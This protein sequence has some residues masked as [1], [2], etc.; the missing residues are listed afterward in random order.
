[1]TNHLVPLVSI[2]VPIYGVEDYIEKCAISILNQTYEN[3]EYI[4]VDDCTK[5]N[6]V[7]I[8][9]NV[10]EKYPNRME[11]CIIIKHEMNKGL[12]AARNTGVNRAKGDFVMHVD[13]DD[14]LEENAVELFVLK[15]FEGDYD[16]V[17]CESV[18]EW[19]N[20][21]EVIN[22][23][24]VQNKTEYLANIL[25]GRLPHNMWGNLIRIELYRRNNVTQ[26]EAV[27][28]GEDYA[29]IPIL[30]FYAKNIGLL[31][32]GLYHYNFQNTTSYV[33]NFSK[34][35]SEESWKGIDNIYMF[36]ERHDSS[37]LKYINQYK[38]RHIISYMIAS[39]R[40]KDHEYYNICKLRERNL[41]YVNTDFLDF[42]YKFFYFL[43]FK[44]LRR[45]YVSIMTDVWRIYKFHIKIK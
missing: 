12:A 23:C 16:I 35:K 43:K 5:D 31:H 2:I 21:S 42:G 1:M 8:L 9:R 37:Y 28:M 45:I 15:Q 40:V 39:I 24:N 38:L 19:K 33:H 7:I 10:I 44:L 30:L 13:S 18:R 14:W 17:S 22:I 6:S 41:G 11:R 20:K 4:F 32:N 26:D 27:N 3:I 25:N 36:F 29:T 34:K